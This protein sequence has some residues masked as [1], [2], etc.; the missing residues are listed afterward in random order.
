MSFVAEDVDETTSK[1]RGLGGSVLVEPFDAPPVGRVAV[2][3]DAHGAMFA[4]VSPPTPR[5]AD[6]AAA[7]AADA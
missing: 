3:T 1:A 2:L 6:D 7:A 5:S 4:I